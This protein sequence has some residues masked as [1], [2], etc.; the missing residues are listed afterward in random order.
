MSAKTKPASTNDR[1]VQPAVTFHGELEIPNQCVSNA[2]VVLMLNGM[3]NNRF[4]T[5]TEAL[6]AVREIEVSTL[7]SQVVTC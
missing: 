3:G 5:Q 7:Y 2:A 6:L 1:A 4:F